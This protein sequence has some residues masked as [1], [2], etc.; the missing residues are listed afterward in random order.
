M[1][2][3]CSAVAHAHAKKTPVVWGNN[4]NTR[5]DSLIKI[6]E[7]VVRMITFPSYSESSKPLLQNWEILNVEQLNNHQTTL[8]SK[9]HSYATRRSNNKQLFG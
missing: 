8:N 4:Y 3:S 1:Q 6:Q 7:E 9:L 5:L 2:I